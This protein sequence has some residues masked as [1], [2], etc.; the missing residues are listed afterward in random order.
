MLNNVEKRSRLTDA[1]KETS[2]RPDDIPPAGNKFKKRL[3]NNSIPQGAVP[4]PFLP[5]D[6]IPPRAVTESPSC[7]PWRVGGQ[8]DRCH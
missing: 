7:V 5:P 1:G 2:M 8:G 3:A 6:Y 4:N